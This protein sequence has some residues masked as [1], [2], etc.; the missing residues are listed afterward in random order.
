MHQPD[1]S[2]IL[3]GGS[4]RAAAQDAKRAGYRVYA[5]DRFGDRDLRDDCD[6]WGL[7]EPNADWP[8]IFEAIPPCPIVPCGGFEWPM[9]SSSE[10]LLAEPSLC[11]RLVAFPSAATLANLNSPDWLG[12]I[13]SEAGV[14]FPETWAVKAGMPTRLFCRDQ[15][16]VEPLRGRSERWIAK[17]ISHAGGVGIRRIDRP[18]DISSAEFSQRLQIGKSI[19]ANFFSYQNDGVLKVQ[20][21]GTFAG[22]TY[23]KNP[24]HQFLYGGSYGPLMLHEGVQEKIRSVA[25]AIARRSELLGLFN[26]DL[27]LGSDGSL[28][29]LEVNARYSASMELLQHTRFVQQNVSLID[30]HLRSYQRDPQ[31]ADHIES[32]LKKTSCRIE[33]RFACKRILYCEHDLASC[34]LR[35]ELQMEAQE[36]IEVRWCDIPEDVSTIQRGDPICTLIL[37]GNRSPKETLF[38]S[39]QIARGFS[40]NGTEH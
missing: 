36:G 38:A 2:M 27:I 26:L 25:T 3:I 24:R 22:I 16:P 19:G 9:D 34:G 5:F 31:L 6:F 28:S 1:R 33:G 4:V 15:R 32:T 10:P 37:S 18:T 39:R 29:L 21:L 14:S 20:H 8:S 12:Q 23:R 13:A 30:W 11:G 40:M 17:P 35:L 7:Y